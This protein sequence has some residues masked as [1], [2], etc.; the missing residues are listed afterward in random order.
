VE[1]LGAQRDRKA[2][3]FP[4]SNNDT[5]VAQRRLEDK[6]PEEKTNMDCLGRQTFGCCR[7][8]QQNGLVKETNVTLFA[9]IR[10][11]LIRSGLSIVFWEKDTTRK[12]IQLK[13]DK[14]EQD[15]IKTRQKREAWRSPEKSRVVSVDR[16]RKTEKN[17]KRMV[18]NANTVEKLLKL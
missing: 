7:T 8:H 12:R 10:C 14:S 15:R 18:K 2:E 13:R 17:A 6:Q 16:A 11:F 1:L 4:V 9:K 3:V 5:A